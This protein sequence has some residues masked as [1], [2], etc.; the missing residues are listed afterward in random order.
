MQEQAPLSFDLSL[1]TVLYNVVGL[2]VSYRNGGGWSQNKKGFASDAF[3]GL[4]ELQINE[5]FHVG[6]AYD[7]TASGLAK[8]SNGSHE[9]MINYR[10]KIPG[11]HKG[12]ECPTYW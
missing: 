3:V 4:F 5:N 6:Y 1:V 12:L 7:F 10:I 9:I 8:Y 11:L 2:G